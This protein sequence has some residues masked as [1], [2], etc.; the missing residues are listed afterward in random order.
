MFYIHNTSCISSQPTFQDGALTEYLAPTGNR[1]SVNE[2]SYHQI[3]EKVLR[4]MGKAVRL[5]VG[6]ALP[7]LDGDYHPDG[8]IIGT[9][10]GGMED[11]IK[12]LNQ[13]I[14]YEEGM[15][16]PTNFVQ[17]TANAIAGQV[18]MLSKNKGY[19]IT[20]VHRGHAFEN[21]LL[22]AAM[23]L[24]DHPDCDLLLG[25]VD[26]ISAYNYNIDL[27]AGWFKTT[28]FEGLTMYQQ[29]TVGSYPGEGAAMFRV[30][31]KKAPDAVKVEALTTV[32]TNSVDE[33]QRIF[34]EFL[35]HNNLNAGGN[36]LFLSGENGDSRFQGYYDSCELLLPGETQIARFKHISGEFATATSIALWLSCHLLRTKLVPDHMKK[37]GSTN[38]ATM[39]ASFN[40][41]LIYNNHKGIQ[42]SLILCSMI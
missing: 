26:E 4:R 12:F 6:A 19:N 5:G 9:A 8:I 34:S 39:G 25:A 35:D 2:P 15:L 40:K 33:I 24:C 42:H 1:V 41:I 11:C 22:D 21:A 3:P 36:L 20:H 18:G 28:D 29:G 13:I 7:L 14:E 16:T 31:S 17:S 27:L 30:S 10:N 23:H 37:T 38:N 32:T